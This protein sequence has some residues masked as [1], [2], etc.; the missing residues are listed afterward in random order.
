MDGLLAQLERWAARARAEDAARSRTR[1]R[2]L[3][4]QAAEDARFEG[5]ALDL[6]ERGA[7]VVLLTTTGRSHRGRIVAVA[8]DFFLL[9]DDAGIATF[10][11]FP[12]IAALRPEDG[13]RSGPAASDR[14]APLG[15]RLADVFVGL[16]GDRPRVRIGLEGGGEVLAGELRAAGADVVTVRLDGAPGGTAYVL[17]SAVR[18]LSVLG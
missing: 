2:W 14:T 8:R 12:A 1:E 5:V 10:V 7:G 18:E 15:T 16:A 4:Q 6:A 9:R 17:M 3:R 11:T 13:D